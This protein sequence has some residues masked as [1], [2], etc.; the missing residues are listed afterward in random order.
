VEQ[1]LKRSVDSRC[2]G[3]RLHSRRFCDPQVDNRC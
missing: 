1:D 3:N 2:S